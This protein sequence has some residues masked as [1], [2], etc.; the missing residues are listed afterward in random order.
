MNILYYIIN[1]ILALQFIIVGLYLI[2]L[3]YNPLWADSIGHFFDGDN[4]LGTYVGIAF[5]M[6]GLGIFC[7][8]LNFFR[9]RT[10][11]VRKGKVPIEVDEKIFNVYVSEY[12][13]GLFPGQEASHQLVCRKKKILLS[14][15]IPYLPKS[16]QQII[17]E[18]IFDDI[19]NL[20][21]DKIGYREEVNFTLVF[22]PPSVD[23]AV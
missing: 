7:Y 22:Q 10:Y 20:L 16:E 8:F 1:L 23:V 3:H 14:I 4:L 18:R 17:T 12:L 13:N 6:I 11:Y 9:K 5:L 21:A 15:E 19:L 2:L